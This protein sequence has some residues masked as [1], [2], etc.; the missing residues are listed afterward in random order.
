VYQAGELIELSL[1]RVVGKAT[2]VVYE[3]GTV[4]KREPL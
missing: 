4:I 1:V 3:D 2:M